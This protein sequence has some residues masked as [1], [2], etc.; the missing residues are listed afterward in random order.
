MP[1]PISGD[2]I[3]TVP[4]EQ[5]TYEADSLNH[6]RLGFGLALGMLEAGENALAEAGNWNHSLR[7]WHA[8]E[9][10]LTDFNASE[11]FAQQAQNCDFTAF[12]NVE[13]EMHNDTSREAV[14]DLMVGFM[15]P[16]ERP[17]KTS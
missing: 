13:H 15:D 4:S 17:P 8:K 10:Q 3:S 12:E 11:T 14:Y 6:S 9:D 2:Q 7:L 5:T 1:N 16:R